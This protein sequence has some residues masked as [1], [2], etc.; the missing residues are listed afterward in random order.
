MNRFWK[1]PR[2][3]VVAA[4]GVMIAIGVYYV[5]N[6]LKIVSVG[7]TPQINVKTGS[8]AQFRVTVA[9]ATA[10]LVSFLW[11]ADTC[12]PPLA[13]TPLRRNFISST[14]QNPVWGPVGQPPAPPVLATI[15]DELI[16]SSL[17]DLE[18]SENE[19]AH[20]G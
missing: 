16:P 8:N 14:L 4:L 9:G 3:A 11:R 20:F 13:S 15:S 17:S 6:P 10:P 1:D 7:V 12:T 5:V 18:P 2:A 19:L